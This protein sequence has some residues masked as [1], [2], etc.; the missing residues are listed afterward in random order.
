[1]FK[2]FFDFLKSPNL[3]LSSRATGLTPILRTSLT[4]PP[5][6]VAAPFL[7]STAEGWLWLSILKATTLF[8]SSLKTPAPPPGPT[9]VLSD[10]EGKSFR[11]FLEDL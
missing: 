8:P 1:M 5:T 11:N 9:T 2:D 7:G 10:D 4:I 6:P 3:K